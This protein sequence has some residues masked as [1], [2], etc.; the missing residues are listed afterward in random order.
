M[1]CI[2]LAEIPFNDCIKAIEKTEF[3][4]IRIDK[5]GFSEDQLQALFNI[6]RKTIA[7]CRPCSYTDDKRKA[8]MKLAIDSGARY[9]DIEYEAPEQYSKE[10][11]EYAHNNNTVVIISYH[12][13]DE[14]PEKYQ[15]EHIIEKAELMGADRVKLATTANTT[16]D[17]ARILSLYEQHTNIIAF[18]MGE[19]GIVTRVAAP[20]LGAEFTFAALNK[21]LITAPGQLTYMEFNDIFKLIKNG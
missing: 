10:L 9:I 8:L 1:I 7:T 18:C 12:N 16:A 3:A 21:K 14:T 13:F 20:Y 17:N 4:E 2:S 5:L 6:N 15:L 11:V 19:I